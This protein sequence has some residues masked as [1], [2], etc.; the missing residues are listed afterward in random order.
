MS[1]EEVQ[2]LWDK[3]DSVKEAFD[4]RT[5]HRPDFFIMSLF[6]GTQHVKLGDK[7]IITLINLMPGADVTL[8][9][10]VWD[11]IN[12]NEI[13]RQ[14]AEVLKWIFK[15]FNLVR[16]TCVVPKYNDSALR[17]LKLLGF[18]TEGLVRKGSLYEGVW[19]DCVILGLLREEAFPEGN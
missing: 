7:G 8:H 16:V 10:T 11:K 15:E 5:R 9:M 4:D 14:A 19:Y 13:F 2:E 12:P 3:V 1:K 17:M 18:E 6:N